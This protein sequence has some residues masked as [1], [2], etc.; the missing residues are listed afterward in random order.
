MN[1]EEIE[2]TVLIPCRDEEGVITNTLDKLREPLHKISH[3]I[4]IIDDF[5]KD[6]TFKQVT[7]YNKKYQNIRIIKNKNIGL[8]G[9]INLGIDEAKGRFLV[10]FM[11]D[12]SDSPQ[13]LLKYYNEIK[14]HKYDAIFGSRFNT[15]SSVLDYPKKKLILNR[16]FNFF[17]KIL[18]DIKFND[19][20]NAFKIYKKSSLIEI[21]PLVSENFN[22]FLELP[23]KIVS[24]GFSYKSIP[25][26]WTNRKDGNAKFKI[27]ELGSKYLF[28]LLY[29]YLEKILL[30]KKR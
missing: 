18:F 7:D 14:S 12:L 20:T 24:R 28:T 23:L 29:V 8:G 1:V 5:S 26:S 22:I 4:L 30:K 25:I 19:Y 10:I 21:K 13:D 9:A 17:V 16:I 11:A 2:L 27:N 3:E 15:G 6:N